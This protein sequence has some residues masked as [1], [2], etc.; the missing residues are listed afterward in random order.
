[1]PVDNITPNRSYELPNGANFLSY[2][3]LRLINAIG[4]VDGDV[5]A[6]LASLAS[7]APLED[8]GFSGEPTA[9]TPTSGSNDNKIATTAYV[10]TAIA[11]I[12]GSL[13]DSGSITLIGN[14]DASSGSFPGG[15][16]ASKGDSWIVDTAGTVDS[17]SFNEGDQIIALV[18][19]ASTNTFTG[20]WTKSGATFAI[21]DDAYSAAWDG[22]GSAAPSRNAVY[23]KIESF[24]TSFYTKAQSDAN[25]YTKTYINA[26][27]YTQT[28]IGS[29]FYTKSQVD[30]SISGIFTSAHTWSAAQTH[31]AS[32]YWGK[33]S[34]V[35]ASSTVNLPSDGNFVTISGNTNISAFGSKPAGS[36]YFIRFSGTPTLVNSGNMILI[37]GANIAVTVGSTACFIADNAS[38]TWRMMFFQHADGTP[39]AP[40][41]LAI[42]GRTLATGNANVTPADNTGII[43][44]SS[45]SAQVCNI[46]TNASQACPSPFMVTILR[47]GTGT[48]TVRAASGVSLNGVTAGECTIDS[49]YTGAVLIQ[50]STDFWTITG[51]HGPVS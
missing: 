23:D 15:G 46:Q 13:P 12:V 41:T 6:A 50:M 4:A 48:L 38:G 10:D 42:P 16:T 3:V 34:S 11:S 17:V 31:T 9:P 29:N 7:L 19:N 45:S 40:S 20:N 49:Q 22:D 8:P 26:N 14:W 18:D 5:S 44:F 1:M 21:K 35:A 33:G 32:V 27:F 2:D 36:I 39:V 43:N 24:S 51:A 25:Y 28:Y 37:G 47:R 30:T